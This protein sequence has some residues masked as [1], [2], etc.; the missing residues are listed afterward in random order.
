MREL[1]TTSLILAIIGSLNWGL[2]GLFNFDLVAALFGEMSFI[3]RA[4][5]V[6][7]GIAAFV[8][9]LFALPRET[10]V[11]DTPSGKPTR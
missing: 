8:L 4:I 2:I 6:I 5:Y 3:S 11:T 10:H 1:H 9:L 7:V